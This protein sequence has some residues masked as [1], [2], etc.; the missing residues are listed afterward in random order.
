MF[1][2]IDILST[3]LLNTSSGK[4]L[5]GVDEGMV[6][7]CPYSSFTDVKKKMEFGFPLGL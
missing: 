7:I 3:I 4:P 6:S 5:D 1:S 2:L